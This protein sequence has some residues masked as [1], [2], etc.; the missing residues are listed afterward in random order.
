LLFFS[1]SE[2]KGHLDHTSLLQLFAE[3][4]AGD[5]RAY[6]DDVNRRIDQGI[7]SVSSVLSARPRADGPPVPTPPRP[8][9]HVA[10][11]ARPPLV[12]ENQKAML[13]AGQHLLTHD[14]A[15]AL[16]EFPELGQPQS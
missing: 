8:V 14:Q 4:F 1:R 13:L 16:R 3:K 9:R 10:R 15:R 5:R 7:E 2:D 6:S 12:N 11:P